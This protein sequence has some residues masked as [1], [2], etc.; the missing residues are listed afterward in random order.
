LLAR[1]VVEEDIVFS[2]DQCHTLLV[3]GE[4]MMEFWMPQLSNDIGRRRN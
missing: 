2:E 4:D 1:S 3:D